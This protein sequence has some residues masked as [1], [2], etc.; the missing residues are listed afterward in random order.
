MLARTAL[1]MIRQSIFISPGP[2]GGDGAA[3]GD[4]PL[5]GQNREAA[6]LGA[7]QPRG[8]QP[9]TQVQGLQK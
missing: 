5:A 8:C 2:A 6:R 7:H 3:Q 9:L 4:V 1:K